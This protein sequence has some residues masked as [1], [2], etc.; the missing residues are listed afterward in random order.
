MFSDHRPSG[1][2]HLPYTSF[3]CECGII[4]HAPIVRR[5]GCRGL[6]VSDAKPHPRL[7]VGMQIG[8]HSGMNNYTAVYSWIARA[9]ARLSTCGRNI[10]EDAEDFL[11]GFVEDC[12]ASIRGQ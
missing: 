5:N 12:L 1:V 8:G 6:M 11:I 4:L 2:Y 3:E 10:V 9:R 7:L